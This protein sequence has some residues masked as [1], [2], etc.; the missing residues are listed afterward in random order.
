M[1]RLFTPL[2]IR[3]V[4]LK[5]RIAVSP[6]CQYS[7]EKGFPSEW[8]LVHL[9]SRAAG[10]AGLIIQEA[11]AISPE[12][13]I[14]PEDLGIWNDEQAEAYKKI[15]DFIISMNSVP[16]VQ[17]AHAGRKAS[18]YASWKG[19][20]SVP[21]SEGGWKTYAPSPVT[22]SGKYRV[23]EEMAND[24]IQKVINDFAFAARRSVTAGYKIIELHFAHGYLVNEFL[25]PLSN[26]RIDEYGGNFKNRIRLAVEI[27]CAVRKVIP[28]IMP[29]FVRIS[30]TEWAEGGWTIEDSVKLAVM[31]KSSGADLIDCSGGGNVHYAIIPVSPL[32]QVPFA[33]KIK[34]E[35]DILTGA[36]GLITKPEEA[37]KIIAE[38]KADLVLLGREML[39]NPYW[40]LHAAKHFG[41]ETDYPKQ[42]LRGKV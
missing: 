21:F 29:L 30:C 12:G 14:S 32:Y 39:R 33:E 42:Y 25:S 13:R 11:T 5:N 8:H 34:N 7:A 28:D 10:G 36:V 27:T 22:F 2:K 31:L 37:E 26:F 41:V 15:N 18:A 17:L 9:G 4:E 16:A 19:E 38:G 3:G 35:S 6:M 24:D 1:S 20:G 40:A 23:P